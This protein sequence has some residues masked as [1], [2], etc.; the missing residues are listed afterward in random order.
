MSKNFFWIYGK[1]P[2]I[3]AL[4]SK[5]RIIKEV[6]CLKEYYKEFKKLCDGVIL[7]SSTKADIDK[8]LRAND[9]AHQGVIAL[10][11]S[12]EPWDIY[13]LKSLNKEKSLVVLLDK[14]EDVQNIGAVIRSA[15]AFNVDAILVEKR[16]EVVNSPSI[17][18]TSSGTVENMD[19]IN[20]INLAS[21]LKTL[22][23]MGYWVVGLK[24]DAANDLYSIKKYEKIALVLGAEGQGL[25][26]LTEENCDL[27]A[28]IKINPDCES[29]NVS[30]AAAIAMY[31]LGN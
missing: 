25:R 17:F 9:K 20:F 23:E 13:H 28:A 3:A 8:I 18:K 24:A 5:K 29:L 10:V 14:V 26:R 11:S 6:C 30:N 21:S 12:I 4:K 27:F 16:Y 7:K 22:K 31:E 1:H 19:I 15:F 2:V